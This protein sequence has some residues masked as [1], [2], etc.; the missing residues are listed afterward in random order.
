MN[1]CPRCE[2]GCSP[3]GCS[4]CG[5]Q[6]ETIDGFVA[7]APDLARNSPGFDPEHFRFLAELEAGNF[8]FQ[9]RNRLIL[10]ALEKCG[11][12][13]RDYLEV[14]C[15]TGFVLSA[16]ADAHPEARISGSEIFVDGLSIAARRVPRAT[17]FQMDAQ[18]VPFAEAFDAIGAY[19]V[20]EHIDKDELVLG[21][22]HLA[23]RPGGAILLTVPQHAWL[24]SVQDDWAHHV[25]RYAPGELEDKLAAA[26]FKVQLSTSFVSLLMPALVAS[27]LSRRKKNAGDSDPFAE[28]RIPSWLNRTLLAVMGIE[29]ALIRI[30]LRFPVGGSRLVVARKP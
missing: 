1:R 18:A 12:R 20:V 6:P 2:A 3:D 5:F 28:F 10:W 8:W 24:W 26:G 25:R 14:G 21:Q 19:D 9:A 11:I 17:F 16:V 29:R 30:G 22:L 7:Y 27:R 4:R 23:L 13:P 15:G